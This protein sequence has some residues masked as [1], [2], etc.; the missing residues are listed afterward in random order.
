MFKKG[1]MIRSVW[2]GRWYFGDDDA[3]I[4]SKVDEPLFLK[5]KVF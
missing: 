1:R 4:R 2:S 5:H 3:M